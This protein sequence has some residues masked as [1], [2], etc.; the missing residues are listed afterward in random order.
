M[1]LR[2]DGTPDN[3]EDIMHKNYVTYED[4]EVTREMHNKLEQEYV[5]LADVTMK[6]ATRIA[7]LE[8]LLQQ[9]EEGWLPAPCCG[10]DPNLPSGEGTQYE[11]E[12]D[13]GHF[14]V[15][16]Q[17][18]DTMTIDERVEEPF[19]DFKYSPEY[20]ARASAEA[21]TLWNTRWTGEDK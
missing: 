12:C 4:I 6:Q 17:I 3:G 13:C 5:R 7:T 1:A 9:K 14:C 10:S 18:S 19:T 11:V 8:G 2:P 15:R 16:V 21:K 20:I